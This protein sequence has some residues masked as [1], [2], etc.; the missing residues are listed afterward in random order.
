MLPY[1]TVYSVDYRFADMI[2]IMAK[3]G[4]ILQPRVS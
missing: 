3:R 1:F 2:N 4:G